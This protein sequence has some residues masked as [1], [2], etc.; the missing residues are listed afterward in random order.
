MKTLLDETK[1][2]AN[3][4]QQDLKLEALVLSYRNTLQT[5]AEMRKAQ[6]TYFKEKDAKQRQHLLVVAK[7]LEQAVDMR[8]STLEIKAVGN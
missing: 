5:C 8:L 1:Q 4:L 6:T 2:A 3:R 7:R